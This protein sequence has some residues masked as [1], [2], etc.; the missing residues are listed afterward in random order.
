MNIS[1]I[2]NYSPRTSSVQNIFRLLLGVALLYAGISHLTF[3]RT[4]FLA[5]VPSWLPLDGDLVVVLSG[6]VEIVLG[7]GLIVLRRYRALVGW[8]TA[9]FFVVIF[10]GNISQ[11]VNGIDAF[12]LNTD[13]ARF[14]RLFFQP[15][16]VLWA[17]WSTGAW[18]AWRSRHQDATQ[19]PLSE[20][21]R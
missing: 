18:R 15:L 9:I 11:Y 3:A 10:P 8:V 14:V 12:G 5:Q 13:T 6:I 17:L 19:R 2:I 4:E 7:I 20:T 16:L 1:H 21:G